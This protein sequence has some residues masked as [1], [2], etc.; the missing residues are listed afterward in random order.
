MKDVLDQGLSTTQTSV[1]VSHP[2]QNSLAKE[3][4]C[5]FGEHSEETED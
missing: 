2:V 3:E 5:K 4:I 1:R